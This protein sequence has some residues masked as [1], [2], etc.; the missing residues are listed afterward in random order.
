MKNGGSQVI[1]YKWSPTSNQLQETT[2]DWPN[3][4]SDHL[5]ETTHKWPSTSDHLPVSTYK[6]L[7][8]HHNYHL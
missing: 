3:L 8:T 6:W 4:S 1:T 5:Q 2:Y 7:C